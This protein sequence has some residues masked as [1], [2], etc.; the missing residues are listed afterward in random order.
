MLKKIQEAEAKGLD[1]KVLARAL[2]DDLD[3]DAAIDVVL[4]SFD[5][6]SVQ[7]TLAAMHPMEP[8]IQTHN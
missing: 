1:V 7:N 4:N 5:E 3:N 8:N 2:I 6:E